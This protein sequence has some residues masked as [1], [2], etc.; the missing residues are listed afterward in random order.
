[1][2]DNGNWLDPLM[3]AAFRDGR[4]P[5]LDPIT[6][7]W[8]YDGKPLRRAKKLLRQAEPKRRQDSP[9]SRNKKARLR[10]ALWEKGVRSCFVCGEPFVSLAEATLEHIQPARYG[11]RTAHGN[12]SLSHDACNQRRGAP[13][14]DPLLPVSKW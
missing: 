1:M 8:M 14:H 2:S 5:I 12:V 6:Q 3:I 11:G 9:K 13:L 7:R 10:R 4:Y